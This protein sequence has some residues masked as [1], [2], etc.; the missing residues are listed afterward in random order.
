MDILIEECIGKEDEEGYI[1]YE[2][3]GEHS[4]F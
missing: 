4:N 3:N 1:P 2:G